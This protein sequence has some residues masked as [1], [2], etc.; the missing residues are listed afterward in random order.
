MLRL[1]LVKK[2]GG[3]RP[4]FWEEY[5]LYL[6]YLQSSHLSPVHI[7]RPLYYY[8]RRP[9]SLSLTASPD[10]VRAGWEELESIWG[11][12]TLKKFGWNGD[13]GYL[14]EEGQK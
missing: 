2:I 12:A 1:D 7:P 3:Y 8:Y 9:G 4:V 11:E 14:P 6:R 5:D 10:R 13:T